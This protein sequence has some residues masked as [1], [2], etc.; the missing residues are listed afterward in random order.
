MRHLACTG[1]KLPPTYS[2]KRAS[3]AKESAQKSAQ[4]SASE[5]VQPLVK[6]LVLQSEQV[7]VLLL[8]MRSAQSLVLQSE[9]VQM[10]TLACTI[11]THSS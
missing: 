2:Q 11:S 3:A 1:L 9:G 4:L 8:G 5:S 10:L 6:A 7:P